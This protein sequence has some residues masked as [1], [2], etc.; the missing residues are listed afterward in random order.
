MPFARA[1][2]PG[3]LRT[4]ARTASISGT[5]KVA[6]SGV[7]RGPARQHQAS[8]VQGTVTES[9]AAQAPPAPS[10]PPP[11]PTGGRELAD[12][13]SRLADLRSSGLLTDVEFSAA[14]ARLLM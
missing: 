6:T 10:P 14:K 8:A 11:A 13:L 12:Q 7:N 9:V 3:L 2:R 1:G 5:A 4:V